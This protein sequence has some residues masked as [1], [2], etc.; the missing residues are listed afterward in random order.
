MPNT[1]LLSW[2]ETGSRYFETGVSNCVLYPYD[3][4]AADQTQVYGPGVAWNGITGIDESPDGADATD[5]WA[6]NIKYATLRAPEDYGGSISAYTYPD[7]FEEC[8]GSASVI[9]GV[10]IG[11]QARKTF[12]LCYRTNIGSDVDT[13]AETDYYL[14]LVYGCTASPSDRS[15]ESINDNPDAIEFEWDF[16]TTPVNVPVTGGVTYKPTAHI[17]ID[18]RQFNTTAL[19]AKLDALKAKLYGTPAGTGTDAVPAYLPLPA[20][21]ISTL[22]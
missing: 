3:K 12:G 9:D 15:Y 17:K 8:D 21:V 16:E 1:Y 13:S 7:E 4:D 18:S 22:S 14:H 10:H 6:D 5:L 2:D 11:Q 20:E 19:Q